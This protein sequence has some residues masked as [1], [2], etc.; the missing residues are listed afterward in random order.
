[1]TQS[2]VASHMQDIVYPATRQAVSVLGEAGLRALHLGSPAFDPWRDEDIHPYCDLDLLL[3]DADLPAFRQTMEAAG[4]RLIMDDPHT[5]TCSEAPAAVVEKMLTRPND[6]HLGYSRQT[7]YPVDLWVTFGTTW[8]HGFLQ[9]VDLRGWFDPGES[10]TITVLGDTPIE[11]APLWGL[12][13]W[14]AAARPRRGASAPVPWTFR[15]QT[16]T[17]RD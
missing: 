16:Q 5:D 7:M 17:Y 8:R 10:E 2:D 12:V 6:P 1:M 9:L 14:H 15:D 3:Q 4:Y 13:L 11:R